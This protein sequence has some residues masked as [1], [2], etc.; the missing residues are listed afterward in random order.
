MAQQG[1]DRRNIFFRH[2]GDI[3]GIIN[4]L[5]YLQALGITAIWINPLLENDQPYESYHGY[6]ITDHYRIDPRFGTNALYKQLGS[7][8]SS[9]WY[10]GRDGYY[11]QS[12]R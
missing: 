6:A 5:D 2:G 9:A 1:V 4:H 10:K 8:L 11:S 3:Q 7:S 12:R